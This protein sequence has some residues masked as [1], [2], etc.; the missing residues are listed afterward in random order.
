M[1]LHRFYTGLSSNRISSY[2]MENP[3]TTFRPILFS[4]PMVQALLEGRKTMTRRVVKPQ[5]ESIDFYEDRNVWFPEVSKCPYEVGDVLWVRETCYPLRIVDASDKEQILYRANLFDERFIKGIGGKWKPSLFMPKHA[6]RIF[7]KVKAIRVERLQDINLYDII[8]EGVQLDVFKIR[9][10]L[11]KYGKDNPAFYF[12]P[13]GRVATDDEV[14]KLA[15][16]DL[17]ISINGMQSWISNPFVWVYEFERIEK[18][19]DFIV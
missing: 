13:E 3:K 7:L 4:T 12:L 19:L 8:N 9:N 5:P 14:H 6:C 1:V 17:W 15:W 2:I 16:A 10:L 18:P 11:E